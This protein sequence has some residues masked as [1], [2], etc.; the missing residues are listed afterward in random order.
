MDASV[1]RR[2]ALLRDSD[3]PAR[4]A[5]PGPVVAEVGPPETED[6]VVETANDAA[7]GRR[8]RAHER[9]YAASI[10]CPACEECLE[11]QSSIL[12]S[13]RCD[14]CGHVLAFEEVMA[15]RMAEHSRTS[16]YV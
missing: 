12:E 13:L 9:P 2:R 14:R 11:L 16:R 7:P 15:L 8:A 6:E 3:A 5:K 10:E 4:V 1:L